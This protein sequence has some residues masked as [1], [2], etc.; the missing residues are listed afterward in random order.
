MTSAEARAWFQA[1]IDAFNRDDFAGFSAYYHPDVRFEGA[2]ATLDGAAAIVDFYRGVK[3]KLVETLTVR[4]FIAALDKGRMAVELETE[5]V[6]KEDWPDF[7]T[8]AFAKGD[9]RVTLNFIFYEIDADLKFT[10]I[11]S[12]RFQRL[13]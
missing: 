1:Y 12:A 7:P 4:Q 8:G 11:R 3:Q 10:R 2:A 13:V 9:R 5:L 6:A